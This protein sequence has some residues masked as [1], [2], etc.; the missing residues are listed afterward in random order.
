MGDMLTGLATWF[1]HNPEVFIFVLG[2]V[3]GYLVGK[4]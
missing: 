1:G 2:F 4:R 3:I